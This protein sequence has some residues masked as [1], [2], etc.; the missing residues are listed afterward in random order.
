MLNTHEGRVLAK[1]VERHKFLEVI[2]EA[3]QKGGLSVLDRRSGLC[4]VIDHP[5]QLDDLVRNGAEWYLN[6]PHNGIGSW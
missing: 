6:S 1:V 2:D 5:D 4:V 3:S